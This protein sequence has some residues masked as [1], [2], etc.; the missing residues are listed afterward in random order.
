[1]LLLSTSSL[2]WYGLHRIFD[3]AKKSGFDWLDLSLN[4]F[5]HDLWDEEYIKYLSNSFDLP[6]LSITAPPKWM[7]EKK[8]DKIVK[9]ASALKAQVLNFS[10]PH[11]SDKNTT[12]YSRYLLKVK[13]D[14][15]LSISIQNVDPK[16]IFFLIPEYKNT[17]LAEIKKLTGETT[18]DLSA[19]DSSSWYDILKAQKL[20]WSSLKNIFLSDRHGNQHGVLPGWAWW[21][22]SYLPLESFFYKLKTTWYNWFITLKVK[23]TELGAWNEDRVIQNLEFV[24][25]YYEKHFL[26]YK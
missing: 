12:W 13:R 24:K 1:M 21:G 9:I 14:T 18:L 19:I 7:N 26:L 4:S 5:N 15:H 16:F 3:F 20:L 11:I 23:P 17:A 10:P 22:I 6:V 8:V 2:Q 25:S